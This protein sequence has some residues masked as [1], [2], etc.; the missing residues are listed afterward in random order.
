MAA[1]GGRG[2]MEEVFTQGY[3]HDLVG[4][5]RAHSP[6]YGDGF[7]GFYIRHISADHT[8]QTCTVY[9]VNYT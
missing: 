3:A 5:G 1:L 8:H 9:C 4:D 6:D 2:G 7:T